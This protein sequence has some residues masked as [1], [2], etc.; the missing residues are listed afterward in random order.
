MSHIRQQLREAF[1]AQVTGL[2]TTG[3]RVFQSRIRNLAAADLPALRIYTDQE[4]VEDGSILDVPWEQRR[5]ILLRCEAVAKAAA[6][7]DDT[8][9]LMCK[10]VEVAIAA[11]STLGGLALLH[12]SLAS[13]E[14]QMDG[15]SEVPAGMATMSW[16][17]E[18]FTMSNAP[19]VPAQ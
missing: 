11:N 18:A 16:K 8:L 15:N 13:T 12:C 6:N 4:T 2:T 5:T 9:D 1:A 17:I 7:L 10:E 19:D 14:I 3:A